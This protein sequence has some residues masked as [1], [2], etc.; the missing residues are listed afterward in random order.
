MVKKSSTITLS[1]LLAATGVLAACGSNGAPQGADPAKDAEGKPVEISIMSDY[2]SPEPPSEQD[3]IRKEIE[4]KTNTKLNITWVSSNNYAEKTNVTLAS[5]D[6]PELLLLRDPFQT[7]V[8]KMAEQGAFWDLTPFLK[9]YKNLSAFPQESWKNTSLNGNYYGIPFVRPIHGTE[10]MPILRKDW[11]DQL[12]LQPP[13]TLDEIYKI[14]KAF[15][16]NDPDGNGKKDTIGLTASVS[17]TAMGSLSWVENVQNG[18]YGKWKE[19]DGKLIDMTLEP[20]TREA[21]LWLNKAYKEG[22]LAAD[23]PTL[24]N[25]QM[26]ESITTNKAGI[27]ADAIKPT[28]LLTGQMR[29]NNPK[30]DLLY[31]PYLDGP[32][33]RFAP[34]GSGAYG[35]W[36][37]PK[38]VPEAKMKQ[39]LA[40]MDYGASEEGSVMANFGF[41]GEHYNQQDGMYLFTEKAKA[42]T[43]VIF[44]IFQSV[45]KY[46]FAYQTGIPADFLKRNMTIIDEQAKESKGDPAIGL[47]SDTY[48]KVG[49]DYDK[50]TQ[51][52][53]VKVILGR[54]PI[55]AWDKYTAD[56]KADAQYQKIVSELNE[57]YK[58]RQ[59][60]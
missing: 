10:G 57:D 48:T 58:K 37:I 1:L 46:A 29:P 24:K 5:G 50:R 52:M 15:T 14:M 39:I 7:Q 56:L 26:R 59:G 17:Q 4:K 11:L 49:S 51:D 21:L 18:S 38:S 55:E 35:F 20:G 28:W 44:P 30:A 3:P 23:F 2:F 16:E 41:K 47:T 33:G 12:G 27:F 45:D 19:K 22:L 32:Q 53:K 8:R 6:M 60:K 34:K 13:K 42:Y 9:D 40:F 54:E 25:T 31:L 36:V 43:G